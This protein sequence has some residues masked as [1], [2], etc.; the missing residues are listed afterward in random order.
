MSRGTERHPLTVLPVAG[1]DLLRHL[2]GDVALLSPL[3]QVQQVSSEARGWLE[4]SACREVKRWIMRKD[5]VRVT[6]R[7]SECV[8]HITWALCVF[9]C[10]CDLVSLYLWG[11]K[12][13][14]PLTVW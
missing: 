6:K 2:D 12:T 7:G 5:K 11:H 4:N 8:T 9:L 1:E 14:S 13:R 10:V 3:V